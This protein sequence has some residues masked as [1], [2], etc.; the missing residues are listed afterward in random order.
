[1]NKINICIR[2][3]LVQEVR[4]DSI[5]VEINV[6]DLD[7]A[8]ELADAWKKETANQEQYIY[9]TSYIGH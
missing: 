6:F 5:E 1:M 9:D 3:G 7:S 8:P 4:V 2:G